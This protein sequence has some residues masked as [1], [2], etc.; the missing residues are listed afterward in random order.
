M[1]LKLLAVTVLS[2][3]SVFTGTVNAQND[4]NKDLVKDKTITMQLIDNSLEQQSLEFA[5]IQFES[6]IKTMLVGQ[7]FEYKRSFFARN[8][9]QSRSDKSMSEE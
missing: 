4:V 6:D 5:K 9:E 2:V 1:K 7:P 3:L 8:T